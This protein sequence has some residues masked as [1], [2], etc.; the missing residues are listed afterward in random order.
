MGTSIGFA[1][2]EPRSQLSSENSYKLDTIPQSVDLEKQRGDAGSTISQPVC[3]FSITTAIQSNASE[4]LGY[5][6]Q[7]P[8]EYHTSVSSGVGTKST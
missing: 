8:S 1:T 2:V 7:T 6:L 5:A 4:Q 3:A